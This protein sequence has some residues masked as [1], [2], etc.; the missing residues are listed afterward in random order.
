MTAPRTEMF[1][2]IGGPLDGVEMPVE[3]DDQGVPAEMATHPDF[4]APNHAIRATD[5]I[6]SQLIANMY[7]RREG[8]GDDGFTYEFHFVASATIDQNQRRAA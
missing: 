4:T 3:V 2:H 8:F 7:E 5:G 6:Q 1:K